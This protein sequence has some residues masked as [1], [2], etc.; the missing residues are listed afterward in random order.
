MRTIQQRQRNKEYEFKFSAVVRRCCAGVW[1]P[2]SRRRPRLGSPGRS[3]GLSLFLS[4]SLSV[5][6]SF[7]RPTCETRFFVWVSF[8]FDCLVAHVK[9][10]CPTQH[11]IPTR[12]REKTEPNP[13]K[14]FSYLFALLSYTQLRRETLLFLKI[15]QTFSVRVLHLVPL[16]LCHEGRTN[17]PPTFPSISSPRE[18]LWES[19]GE[20]ARSRRPSERERERERGQE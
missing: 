10:K 15:E 1:L 17:F 19:R 11:A 5:S 6:V 14:P 13:K 20:K 2:A 18:T 4:L 16:L 9:T 7:G 8:V 3:A 12:S